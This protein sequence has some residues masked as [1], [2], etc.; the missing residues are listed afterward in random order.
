VDSAA[1]ALSVRTVLPSGTP[2]T[3]VTNAE[4]KEVIVSTTHPIV[5]LGWGGMVVPL[6][7]TA[8][9]PGRTLAQGQQLASV[10]A[11]KGDLGADSTTAVAT[12]SMPPLS[13]GW[14]LH[15]AL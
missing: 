2:V 5:E 15:H 10:S 14:K 7:I 3:K 4:H 1:A 8:T 6:R 9:L 12:S 11:V 13:F